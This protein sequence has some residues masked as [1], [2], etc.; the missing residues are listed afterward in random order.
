VK[1]AVWIALL[2]AVAFIA[3]VIAR[4]PAAWF[5]PAGRGAGGCASI[6]GSLWSGTCTDLSVNGTPVGDVSWDLHPLALLKGRLGA[7]VT[8]VRGPANA[9]ADVELGLGQR[10]TARNVVADLP[11]DSKLI[12]A[13]P[14]T[15]HG[16][17]HVELALL[18]LDHGVVSELNGRMEAHDLEDRAGADTPL[19][20]YVVTFPGGSGEQVGKLRDLDGP[21]ALEGTLRLT[22]QPAGFELEGLV[23]PRGGAP[24]EI[25]NNLRFFGS[26]DASGRRP[27]SL[28][29]TF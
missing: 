22:R 10:V 27:F 23:A 11:L 8:V 7:H 15:L 20:S 9:G 13:V 25:V 17:A 24:P 28:S 26:P 14:A 12:P 18:Q 21:L 16:R 19:G 2:A 4:M 5:L 1:R 3:I 29:G 6:E